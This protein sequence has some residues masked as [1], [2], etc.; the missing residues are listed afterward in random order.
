MI[1]EFKHKGL[2]ELYRR[3]SSRGVQQ[4]HVDKLRRILSSLEAAKEPKDM[5]LP[6]YK[7]HPLKGDQKGVWAVSVNGN[8]RVTWKFS[9]SD[10]EFVDY[11]DYH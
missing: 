8:W 9:G 5:N 11:V 2:E 1:T 3:D 6:G 10:V 4:G 7:L